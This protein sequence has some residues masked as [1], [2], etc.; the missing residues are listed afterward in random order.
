MEWKKNSD[1]IWVI[2]LD[3]LLYPCNVIY[4]DVLLY[5]RNE[6]RGIIL[7]SHCPYVDERAV[8]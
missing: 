2:Y 3:V 4:L 5:P 8:R 7:E 1:C 6:V